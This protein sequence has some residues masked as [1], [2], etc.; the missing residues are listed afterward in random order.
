MRIPLRQM[1]ANI[2]DGKTD[3]LFRP[4]TRTA[5]WLV[6]AATIFYQDVSLRRAYEAPLLWL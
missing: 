1:G 4:W 6:C 3:L 5:G 2:C